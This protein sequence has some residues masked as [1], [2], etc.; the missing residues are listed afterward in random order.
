MGFW[1][2]AF[3]LWAIFHFWRLRSIFK[4]YEFLKDLN[5]PVNKSTL[6]FI[7][8]DYNRWNFT[9]FYLVGLITIPVRIVLICVPILILYVCFKLAIFFYGVKTL[10]GPLNPKFIQFC[11]KCTTV[12]VRIVTFG[13][14]YW[15]IDRVKRDPNPENL[16]YFKREK[17]TRQATIVANHSSFLDIFFMLTREDPVCFIS[18]HHA[19]NYFLIGIMGEVIQCVFLNRTSKESREKVFDFL[20]LR[21][22][23]LKENPKG[24]HLQVLKYKRK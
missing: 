11:G 3:L 9:S 2:I 4:K 24:N 14:G 23:M 18:N 6:P 16:E 17:E 12:C 5:V 15:T 19:R 20:K 8:D 22:Q 1:C 13:F 7:R 10:E 21:V